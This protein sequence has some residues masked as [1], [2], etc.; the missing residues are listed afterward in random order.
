MLTSFF[1]FFVTFGQKAA[2]PASLFATD[3]PLPQP[4]SRYLYLVVVRRQL[5]EELSNPVLLSGAVDVRHLVLGETGEIH[6]DLQTETH[7]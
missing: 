4:L 6:L 1:F 2:A 3:H 7:E 5:V